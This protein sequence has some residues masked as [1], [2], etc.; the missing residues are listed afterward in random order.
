MFAMQDGNICFLGLL[1]R[2]TR[3]KGWWFVDTL[4]KPKFFCV[5]V[6]VCVCVYITVQ[7][8]DVQILR[9]ELCH[10]NF[11]LI[12]EFEMMYRMQNLQSC[13]IVELELIETLWNLHVI[14]NFI[15]N[16]SIAKKIG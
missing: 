3:S 4:N 15:A 8:W 6:C 7:N 5:C 13:R 11:N 1:R 2:Y 12:L 9:V 10:L 14:T 16:Y